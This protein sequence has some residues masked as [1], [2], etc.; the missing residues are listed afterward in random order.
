MMLEHALLAVC[1][2]RKGMLYDAYFND[3][4]HLQLS[5]RQ[6]FSS[7]WTDFHEHHR[8]SA[9]GR[10]PSANAAQHFAD[11]AQEPEEMD[12]R[13]ARDLAEALR[14]ARSMSSLQPIVVFAAPRMLGE[15]RRELAQDSG[16]LLRRGE[17]TRLRP[18][19]LAAH[20]LIRA[21][22]RGVFHTAWIE[23]KTPSNIEEV[24]P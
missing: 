6:Q 14:G 5:C 3:A 2:G 8:P 1:D 18:S 9:L 11:S 12:R 20:P 19:E 24:R 17:L 23:P 13:F 16:F 10:G 4:G 22:V 7:R 15:L 21:A